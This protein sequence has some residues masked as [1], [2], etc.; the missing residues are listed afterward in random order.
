MKLFWY[1][2]IANNFERLIHSFGVFPSH[3]CKLQSFE[4]NLI[5]EM[6]V[7]RVEMFECSKFS[8]NCLITNKVIYAYFR[9][10]LRAY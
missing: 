8:I 6:S 3:R 7:E 9:N 10:G 2:L 4:H 5:C 1:R